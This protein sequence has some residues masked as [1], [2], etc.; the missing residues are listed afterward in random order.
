MYPTAREALAKKVNIPCE[1]VILVIVPRMCMLSVVYL[2]AV[3][4]SSVNIHT[5][6]LGK[7]KKVNNKPKQ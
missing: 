4:I 7:E 6:Q 5:I 1:C 3:T 2:S